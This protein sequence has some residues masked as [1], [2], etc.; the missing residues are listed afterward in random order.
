VRGDWRDVGSS[1][2]ANAETAWL[3]HYTPEDPGGVQAAYMSNGPAEVS[4][5][6]MA[7]YVCM[8]A[9]RPCNVVA[10]N[11]RRDT[12]IKTC[13]AAEELRCRNA[14]LWQWCCSDVGGSVATTVPEEEG[15]GRVPTVAHRGLWHP[16]C[17]GSERHHAEL[18]STSATR[19]GR[20]VS[21]HLCASARRRRRWLFATGTTDAGGIVLIGSSSS[22]SSSSKSGD[23]VRSRM[24]GKC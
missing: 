11:G 21:G 15:S 1:V 4:H 7:A 3:R 8:L 22:S 6:C 9:C 5:G 10:V 16:P 23:D 13:S 24:Q 12:R 14:A 2:G 20:V 18:I 19:R 17:S